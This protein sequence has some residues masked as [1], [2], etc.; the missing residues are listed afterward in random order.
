[1]NKSD[2]EG[3]T[4]IIRDNGIGTNVS[5]EELKEDSLGMDLI[6]SLTEQLDGYI[7]INTENGFEYVF[8]FPDFV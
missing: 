3:K 8:N 4:M 2:T 1:L 5:L 6:Y 7:E